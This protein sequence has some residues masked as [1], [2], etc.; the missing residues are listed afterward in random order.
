VFALAEKEGVPSIGKSSS[1]CCMGVVLRPSLGLLM[2]SRN[3]K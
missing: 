3:A 1:L 2:S